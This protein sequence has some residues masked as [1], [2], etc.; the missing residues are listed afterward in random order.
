MSDPK[1]PSRRLTLADAIYIW[2]AYLA[3]AYQHRI[4]ADLD[5]NPGRVNEVLKGKRYPE[6]RM[7][8]SPA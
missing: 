1:R 5:V 4:A 8:A 2:R 6:S 3:G 7:M